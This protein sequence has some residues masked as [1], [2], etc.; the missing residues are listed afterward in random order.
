MNKICP[1]CKKEVFATDIK[2]LHC[3]RVLKEEIYIDILNILQPETNKQKNFF[4]NNLKDFF[5]KKTIN[6]QKKIHQGKTDFFN[7]IKDSLS[8]IIVMLTIFMFLFFFYK[9]TAISHPSIPVISEKEANYVEIPTLSPSPIPR[10]PKTFVSLN[11][12]KIFSKNILYLNGLGKLNIENGSNNDA[13]AKL[14]NISINKSIYTVYIR[15]NSSYSINNISDGE[16]ELFFNIGNDWDNKS[17]SFVEN[18]SFEKF[19]EKF[20]YNTIDQEVGNYIHTQ[21][22]TYTTTLNPVVDGTAKT[23]NINDSTFARY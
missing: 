15:A 18:S 2:C 19:E 1:F 9:N 3:T 16:Y 6:F 17:R 8:P 20:I 14:V 4:K 23:T 7:F 10:D 22:S 12:G 11:N 21:Y 5:R 13:L